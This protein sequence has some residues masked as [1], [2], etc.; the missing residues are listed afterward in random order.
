VVVQSDYEAPPRAKPYCALKALSGRN[1][2]NS[3]PTCQFG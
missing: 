1:V 3:N 2:T